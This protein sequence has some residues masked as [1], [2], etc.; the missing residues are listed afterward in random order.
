[1]GVTYFK[2]YRMEIGL[3]RNM[4][5]APQLPFG[6][7]LEPWRRELVRVHAATKYRSFCAEIDSHVFPCLGELDGC[8]Q[9]MEDISEKPG[10]LPEA[11]WLAVHE[12]GE[13]TP[14]RTDP[15]YCG[16][17]QGIIDEHGCGGIQNLG[18]IPEFRGLGIGTCL[19]LR[20]LEG[21]WRAGLRYASL[22]VT[23]QNEH[24][25][26]LYRKLG[27]RRVKTVYKAVEVAYS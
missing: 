6:Y 9:L 12:G 22:E 11:T 5:P 4:F 14:T 27:F 10:F 7:R 17:V 24:A 16:T 21:F 15:V 26:T 1:M 20:A 8:Q 19:L 13:E 3:Q 2:R 25:V 18:V 23:A